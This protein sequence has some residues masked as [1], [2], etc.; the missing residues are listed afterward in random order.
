MGGDFN[1]NAGNAA[2]YTALIA[3]LGGSSIV[4][5]LHVE[6]HGD[7]VSWR[8]STTTTGM[9]M[10]CTPGVEMTWGTSSMGVCP[11]EGVVARGV[12]LLD[13]IIAL[14]A[15]PSSGT[16]LA[17]LTASENEVLSYSDASY[18]WLQLADGMTSNSLSDHQGRSVTLSHPYRLKGSSANR[19]SLIM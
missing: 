18:T 3:G 8:D 17:V 6:E 2:D 7:W 15:T 16:Q 9:L 13:Y 10:T 11:A 5:D 12:S 14:D 19:A 4:R 1:M